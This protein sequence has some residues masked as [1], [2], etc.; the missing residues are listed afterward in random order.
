MES[1]FLVVNQLLK[2]NFS[3]QG[4]C[5]IKSLMHEFQV[6]TAHHVPLKINCGVGHFGLF[7]HQTK[8]AVVTKMFGIHELCKIV[9]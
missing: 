8:M 2:L 7:L 3:Y 6:N 5:E 4:Q 1:I 9:L